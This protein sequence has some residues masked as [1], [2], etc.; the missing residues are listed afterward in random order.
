MSQL[1]IHNAKLISPH[2][3]NRGGVLVTDERISL[4]FAETEKPT[5]LTSA[6]TVDLAGGYLAPGMIDLHIHG[7][8]GVDVLDADADALARLSEFLLTEGVTGYFA[9]LVPADEEHYRKALAEIASYTKN[10]TAGARILGIHFEGPFVSHNRCGALQP[11][12]FR[13]F[14][15]DSQT[16][17]LFTELR[18]VSSLP[19]LMTLAPEIEGGLDLIL[20]L[21]N[22]GVRPF[23]GHTEADPETLDRAAEAGA[24]HI[25]HFPNALNPL[26]HRKPGAVAWGLVRGDITA[27]CIA[28]FHHVHP[29]MLKLIYQAKGAGGLALIS[30]AILPTGLGDGEFTVWGDRISVREG[31]TSLVGGPSE[32]TIAG[33]VITMRQALRNAVSLGIAV[34]D[35]V[36]MAAGVPARVC[37]L[38]SDYGSL[39]E[40]KRADI[41]GFDDELGV[42][43]A[44][45]GGSVKLD[46]R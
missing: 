1:L 24:R 43:L 28:D 39:E 2:G 20:A 34:E 12:F 37:G 27:D 31:L 42:M 29:L 9:T 33:S 17:D 41:V 44:V 5:G 18:E 38:D 45:V 7:S 40:K 25:T 46:R 4:I 3:I 14:N 13:T 8:V 26:H 11:D 36:R 19:T 23:I 22:R 16:L 6:E 15:G 32:G 10:A 21:T 30:D 35:A